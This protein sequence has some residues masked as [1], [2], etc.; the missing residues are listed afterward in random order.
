VNGLERLVH[1][2]DHFWRESVGSVHQAAAAS[3]AAS[4]RG[5]PRPSAVHR[6]IALPRVVRT[7]PAC[8]RSSFE[9]R[10]ARASSDNGGAVAQG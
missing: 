1:F 7:G 3:A 6:P 2:L 8:G 9:A 5:R 4:G 10:F